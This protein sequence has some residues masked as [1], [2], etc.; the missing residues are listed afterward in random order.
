MKEGNTFDLSMVFVLHCQWNMSPNM[1]LYNY[2]KT[3]CSIFYV[4]IEYIQSS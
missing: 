3:T 2:K 1:T 4:Y